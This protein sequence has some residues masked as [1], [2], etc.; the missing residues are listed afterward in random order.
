[1]HSPPIKST[2]SG[3]AVE[4]YPAEM[5]DIKSSRYWFEVSKFDKIRYD[6]DLRALEESKHTVLF[7]DQEAARTE[8]FKWYCAEF[9]EP[10]RPDSFEKDLRQGIPADSLRDRVEIVTRY[11]CYVHEIWEFEKCDEENCRCSQS[12]VAILLPE[13]KEETQEEMWREA[14]DMIDV[15]SRD[16]YGYPGAINEVKLKYKITRI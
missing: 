4:Y 7:Q 16:S 2:Q 10:Y 8:L 1:M 15:K 13:I 9:G 11:H 3:I 5:P 14:I 6:L 12:E